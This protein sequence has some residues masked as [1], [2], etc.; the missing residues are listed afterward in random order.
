MRK[1]ENGYIVVETIGAFTLFVFFVASILALIN[2]V[3]LQARVHNAI[4]QAAQTVS[5]YSYVLELTGVSGFKQ[6]VAGRADEAGAQ[7]QNFADN[8]DA[9]VDGIRN[10]SPDQVQGGFQGASDQAEQ[11]LD[12][13]KEFLS[14]ASNF[15]IEQLAN[16]GFG[17]LIR[18]LIGHYLK[19]GAMSGDDYLRQMHVIDG[20]DGLSFYQFDLSNANDST[21][22]NAAG[23]LVISVEYSV[24]YGA[25][26]PLPFE[27]KL[28]I[29]Q[30]VRTRPW[31]HGSGEGYTEVG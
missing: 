18:P 7:A 16:A 14:L 11:W 20:L 19:N 23:D 15:G 12:D 13:P 26:L 1:D 31:G 29:R 8:V 5:M 27:P 24:E 2:I 3:A 9:V 6:D 21:I 25:G 28:T 4:T 22:I 17:T 30:L 10:L